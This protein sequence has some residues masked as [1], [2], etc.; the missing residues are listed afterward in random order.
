M[1]S[2][3]GSARK[4]DSSRHTSRRS[5]DRIPPTSSAIDTTLIARGRFFR[6]PISQSRAA[7]SPRR[8][9]INTSES[10]SI[11]MSGPRFVPDALRGRLG[12]APACQRH[13]ERRTNARS[14]EG[15]RRDSRRN[16][17]E[18]GPGVGGSLQHAT[19]PLVLPAG[20]VPPSAAHR[21][22]CSFA[23]YTTLYTTLAASEFGLLPGEYM[24]C[25]NIAHCQSSISTEV[26]LELSTEEGL[27]FRSAGARRQSPGGGAAH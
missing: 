16:W 19:R 1:I 26:G 3:A 7:P 25:S 13:A 8:C 10:T 14:R 15:P 24:H 6:A 2:V 23:L 21:G 12:R 20:R 27:E 22:K 5:T 4:D 18:R 17:P 11:T 9:A